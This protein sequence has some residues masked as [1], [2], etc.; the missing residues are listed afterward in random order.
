[1]LFLLLSLS[2]FILKNKTQHSPKDEV[3]ASNQAS[4]YEQR[5]NQIDATEP[6]KTAILN[7]SQIQEQPTITE[8]SSAAT[9]DSDNQMSRL[10]ILLAEKLAQEG[11][12]EEIESC[13]MS[14]SKV[15]L[16]IKKPPSFDGLADSC[17]EKFQLT[18]TSQL[19]VRKIFRDSINNSSPVVEIDRWYQCASAR[20]LNGQPCLNQYYLEIQSNFYN[21]NRGNSAMIRSELERNWGDAINRDFDKLI[22][23]C[24][25]LP[26]SL[27][28]INANEC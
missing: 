4:D 5:S 3:K 10:A 28:E 11:F 26:S 13:I 20:K 17:S 23:Q 21:E 25:D 14:L 15:N 22:Q 16:S 27:T 1:M 12:S 7:S 19:A 6:N 8:D 9:K 24:P 18:E 2:I